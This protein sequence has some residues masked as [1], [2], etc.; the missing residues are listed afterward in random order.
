MAG[1]GSRASPPTSSPRPAAGCGKSRSRTPSWSSSS[2]A[3]RSFRL[4]CSPA[5][6]SSTCWPTPSPR[7]S[8]RSRA[9][10]RTSISRPFPRSAAQPERKTIP[11]LFGITGFEIRY[12]LRNPVFWVA[13]AIFFLMG[14]GLTASENVSIG[15][16]GAVHQNAPYAIAI[17]TAI[18]TL[19]YLFVVT[20]F[21]ANAIVRDETSGFAPIVRATSVTNTQIVLG[22]FL[23]GLII[24]WLGYLAV[25]LGMGAGSILPWG[26]QETIGPQKLSFYAWN[27]AVFAIPNI[28]LISAVLFALATVLRSMMAAYIGC[29]LLVMGYIVTVSTAGQKIEYRETFAKWEPLGNGALS[30]ATRYWTQADMNTRLVELSG[31]ML[32]NRILCVVLA[33]LF[34]GFTVWRFSMTER[35]PSKRRLR[36][37]AKPEARPAKGA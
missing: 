25:P 12:Q 37:L 20:A 9:G 26:D 21:V 3:T 17:A 23:G 29:V 34:L 16:P 5:R 31:T 30:E 11:M 18:M 15:T 2:K 22:R 24:A 10:S 1:C 8:S 14:F 28:L 4:G 27:F 33:L 7:G 32:F 6:P 36:R 35:A 13:V 19:F